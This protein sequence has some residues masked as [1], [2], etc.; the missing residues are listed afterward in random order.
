[1]RYTYLL[2]SFLVFFTAA[3]CDQSKQKTKILFCIPALCYSGA[4]KVLSNVIS[5]INKLNKYEIGIWVETNMCEDYFLKKLQEMKVNITFNKNDPL[6]A[7]THFGE[8]QTFIQFLK[9]AMQYDIIVD[10]IAD[11]HNPS[12]LTHSD[13]NRLFFINLFKKTAA[14]IHNE[15]TYNCGFE[16]VEMHFPFS[17]YDKII[18]ITKAIQNNFQKH[19]MNNKNKCVLMLNKVD[20]NNII[21]KSRDYS[22]LDKCEKEL[23]K[24]DYFIVA[25]RL[26]IGK[27][28]DKT[29]KAYDK[30]IQHVQHPPYLYIIG[31][32]DQ[33]EYLTNLVLKNCKIGDHIKF[34][35][36]KNNL[37]VWIKNAKAILSSSNTEGAPLIILEAF[38]LGTLIVFADGAKGVCE[39]L[40]NGKYGVLFNS[41]NVESLSKIMMQIH[42]GKITPKQFACDQKEL[43]KKHGLDDAAIEYDELFQ[44]ILH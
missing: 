22:E 33:A 30:F 23:I 21:Q 15:K 31:A 36:K 10:A 9:T 35:N 27:N 7:Q 24:K 38:A 8:I 3:N 39:M 28:I 29:I 17:K 14:W 13:Y 2:L 12:G 43:R 19:F 25:S 5:S 26:N 32:G 34:L 18:C 11:M 37:Y 41:E 42:Q 44:S 20:I 4:E 40:E 16:P 1:M 6:I